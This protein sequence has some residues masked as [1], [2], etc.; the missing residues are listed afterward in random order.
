MP[1]AVL[2]HE[3]QLTLDPCCCWVDAWAFERLATRAGKE[4][5]NEPE[6]AVAASRRSLGLY[7][8]GFMQ[9]EENAAWLL[10]ARERLHNRFL[11]QVEKLGRF[12][13]DNGQW[14]L[15]IDLYWQT[16]AIDPLI[17]SF[18]Q[19]IITCH[20]A[21]GNRGEAARVHASCRETFRQLV[22]TEPSLQNL[23]LTSDLIFN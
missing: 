9:L 7:K 14:R 18:Y 5:E 10:P 12:Y 15:A 22:G 11:S 16:L 3:G 2:Y 13:R 4:L 1:E 20:L 21:I 23:P 17:E 19:S 8:G 6:K